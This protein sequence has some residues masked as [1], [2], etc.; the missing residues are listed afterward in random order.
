MQLIKKIRP[1]HCLLKNFSISLMFC[2]L[3]FLTGVNFIVFPQYNKKEIAASKLP[4][5][6]DSDPSAP[7]EEKSSSTSSVIMQKEYLHE[8]NDLKQFISLMHR[9]CYR[10]PDVEKLP[11]VHCELV[12]PP[13][14]C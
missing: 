1:V 4:G 6:T 14:K 8:K 13:P 7:I 2:S 3:L 5:K 9:N 10:I 12:S 11:V